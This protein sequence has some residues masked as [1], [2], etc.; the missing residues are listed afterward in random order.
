MIHDFAA[1]GESRL[2]GR[3]TALNTSAARLPL[4]ISKGERWNKLCV[5][6]PDIVDDPEDATWLKP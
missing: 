1:V 5:K 3:A 2:W 6:F 4:L